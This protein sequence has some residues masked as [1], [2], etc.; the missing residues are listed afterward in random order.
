MDVT[1]VTS[2]VRMFKSVVRE[3]VFRRCRCAILFEAF[4]LTVLD[5]SELEILFRWA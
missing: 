2:T 3:G 4:R 5:R 1:G